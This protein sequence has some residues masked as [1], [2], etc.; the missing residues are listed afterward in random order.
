MPKFQFSHIK[1]MTQSEKADRA[2]SSCSVTVNFPIAGVFLKL[3]MPE[4]GDYLIL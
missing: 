3:Q 1:L 4:I 2:A